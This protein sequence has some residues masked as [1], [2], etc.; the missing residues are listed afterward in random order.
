MLLD[1]DFVA[2]PLIY[3]LPLIVIVKYQ[4]DNVEEAVNEPIGRSRIDKAME[5]AVKVREVVI[6][7]INFCQQ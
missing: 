4:R 6:P 1:C 2:L 3:L 5:T 7:T